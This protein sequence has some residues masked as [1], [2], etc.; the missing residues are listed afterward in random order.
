VPV[1]YS[2]ENSLVSIYH[3]LD[4]LALLLTHGSQ[5]FSRAFEHHCSEVCRRRFHIVYNGIGERFL[6]I[7]DLLVEGPSTKDRERLE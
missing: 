5:N 3:L 7:I 2:R 4:V 6:D 1:Q